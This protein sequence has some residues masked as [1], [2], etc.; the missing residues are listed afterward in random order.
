MFIPILD[1]LVLSL[2]ESENIGH[3]I[4]IKIGPLLFWWPSQVFVPGACELEGLYM[5]G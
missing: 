4:S 1:V 3:Q 2:S 5:L